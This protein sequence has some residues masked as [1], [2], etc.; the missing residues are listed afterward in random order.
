MADR[1]QPETAGE[2]AQ[3]ATAEAP[4]TWQPS[5]KPEHR[6]GQVSADDYGLIIERGEGG[7]IVAAFGRYLKRPFVKLVI[8]LGLFILAAIVYDATIN[9]GRWTE[10]PAKQ[11]ATPH[12]G[13]RPV[14]ETPDG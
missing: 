1:V 7:G 10:R 11:K 13:L 5:R 4:K 9:F 3:A 2:A 12:K 14:P 8:G 6:I